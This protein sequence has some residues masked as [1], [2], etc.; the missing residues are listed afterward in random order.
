MQPI[1]AE[2]VLD[3]RPPR[4]TGAAAICA[5]VAAA[6]LCLAA[7]APAAA[8]PARPAPKA[9]AAPA[10]HRDETPLPASVG[11][12]ATTSDA[13]P[14]AASGTGAVARMLGGLAVVLA[15]IFGVYWLLKTF[16][17]ARGLQADGRMTVL[18]TTSLSASRTLHLVRVGEELVLLGSSEQ[19]V[20]PIRVYT[21]DEARGLGLEPDAEGA[22]FRALEAP[23][24]ERSPLARVVDELR[25]RSAR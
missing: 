5:A 18:A 8:A 22:A 7:P 24:D 19:S 4:R 14:A 21:A 16:G 3:R 17:R 20:T 2:P 1:T 10:F 15:V 6:C 9:K 13:A 11:G 23:K 12:A 25:R